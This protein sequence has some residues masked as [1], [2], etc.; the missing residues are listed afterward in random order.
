M[1]YRKIK[2]FLYRSAYIRDVLTLMTGTAVAQ[3]IPLL[4]M[5]VISRL[6]TSEDMAVFATYM[7]VISIFGSFISLKYDLA[8][9]LP[10]K[11]KDSMALTILSIVI[12][13]II[14]TLVL[15]IFL[16]FGGDFL[17][18][19]NNKGVTFGNWIFFIPLSIFTIGVFSALNYW[20]TRKTKYKILSVSRVS[21]SSFMIG[22]QMGFGLASLKGIGLI[23][24]EITGRIFAAAILSYKTLKDDFRIIKTIQIKTIISQLKRYKN[25]P[26]F[27][28]PA[29]LVNVTT[30]QIPIFVFGRFF[31]S[32]ILGNYFFM[33]R[34]L[35]APIS[36]IS[37][38]IL[39]VFKQRASSDYVANGNCLGVFMK[40]FK[41]LAFAS[42]IPTIIIFIFSPWAFSFI[43]GSEWEMAGEF[44]RI[45][46][47]LFFFRFTSSPLSY[48]FYIAEK[49][50]YDMIW[51][52]GLFFTTVASFFAGVYFGN[53]KICLWCYAISYSFMYVVYLYISYQLAKGN[54]K[55]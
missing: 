3:L 11:D 31:T 4:L 13:L 22:S 2:D 29:D 26:K 54:L 37:R 51:Q 34:V 1:L 28:L 20:L 15:M 36:L 12:A 32:Q 38:A 30:N 25:F 24:G 17:K 9:I 41:T 18:I 23:T 46:S 5:P 44:A 10:E 6:Y 45:M 48:M 53:I 27:S 50:H 21:Q 52:I 7:S 16:I 55:N 42:I 33:D 43:F 39:D 19:I 35:N 47:V 14:S 40:T 49:Q 8:I